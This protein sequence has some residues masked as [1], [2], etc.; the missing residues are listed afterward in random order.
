MDGCHEVP[1]HAAGAE[2]GDAGL[3]LVRSLVGEGHAEDVALG[4]A[5]FVQEVGIAVDEG[6]G[7]AGSGPGNDADGPF[8]R[9]DGG[10]LLGG[11]RAEC[12]RIS[13]H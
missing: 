13:G 6:A 8:G 11:Q 7:L 3:H 5:E 12:Y 1:D 4:D 9:L 10:F 2:G